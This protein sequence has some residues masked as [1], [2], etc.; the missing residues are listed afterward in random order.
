MGG[1]KR[2]LRG[3]GVNPHQEGSVTP[4]RVCVFVFFLSLFFSVFIVRIYLKGME[5][6]AQQA[7]SSVHL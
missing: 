4:T 6:L 2:P 3:A 1:A 5:W 7:G